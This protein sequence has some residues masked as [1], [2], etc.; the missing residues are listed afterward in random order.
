MD[1]GGTR[2]ASRLGGR[3]GSQQVK[4]RHDHIGWLASQ[5]G[6]DV[7]SPDGGSQEPAR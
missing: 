7:G 3:Q 4:I 6:Y 2:D 1:Q 5:L